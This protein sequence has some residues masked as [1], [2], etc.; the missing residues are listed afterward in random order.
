MDHNWILPE[1]HNRSKLDK[2]DRLVAKKE[3]K[4]V[5]TP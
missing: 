1:R 2:N 5:Y 4:T 3:I